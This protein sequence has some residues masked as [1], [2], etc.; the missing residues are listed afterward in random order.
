M[1]HMPKRSVTR[2]FIPLID[3][4]LLLFCIFL[5]MPVADENKMES[6]LEKNNALQGD[7]EAVNSENE[8]MAGDL[9]QYA[10]NI[11]KLND[12]QKLLDEIDRLKEL[13]RKNLQ[14]RTALHVIDVDGQTGAISYYD[15]SKP[16]GKARIPIDNEKM[17]KELIDRHRKESEKREL[18]YYFLFPRPGSDDVPTST[19]LKNYKHWFEKEKVANSLNEN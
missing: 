6:V 15:R 11:S 4:L 14:Q 10:A 3:V 5:L 2:Y 9:N 16:E 19:Q 18:Y 17:A 12:I 8:R 7:M 1:I 13:S